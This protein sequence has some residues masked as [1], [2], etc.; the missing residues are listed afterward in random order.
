MLL[1][2]PLL[3]ILIQHASNSM[4]LNCE[5]SSQEYQ[6]VLRPDILMNSFENGVMQ[7]VNELAKIEK[8]NIM[9]F[10]V[11]KSSLAFKNVSLARYTIDDSR[12]LSDFYLKPVFKSRRNKPTKP[13]DIVMK[14]SAEDPELICIQLTT[15]TAFADSTTTKF[16]LD[17]HSEN[18]QLTS[19]SGISFKA[20]M[21]LEFDQTSA[22]NVSA[23]FV[24]AGKLTR[25]GKPII[26]V[27]VP[28]DKTIMQTAE[29]NVNLAGHKTGAEII[30]FERGTKVKFEFSFKIKDVTEDPEVF[31]V[32]QQLTS[33]I[34]QLSHIASSAAIDQDK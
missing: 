23:I 14:F 22:V 9:N 12:D 31:R 24:D 33:Y 21:P 28:E 29:F 19:K 10:K 20:D 26:I 15:S 11:S 4:S 32:A 5:Y 13:A 30:Y 2:I 18:G 7:V 25:S 6:V 8:N 3:W 27:T 34:S 1:F 17:I 16:E